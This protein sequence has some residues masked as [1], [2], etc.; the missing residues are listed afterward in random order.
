MIEDTR[1]LPIREIRRKLGMTQE[2][3]AHAIN[4]TV[5]TVNRWEN[6]HAV[7]SRLACRGIA[8]LARAHGIPPRGE[9]HE[10]ALARR[11]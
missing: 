6:M 1:D 7:P 4:V 8:D 9:P 11:Q 5:S 10:G 2:E 3:F